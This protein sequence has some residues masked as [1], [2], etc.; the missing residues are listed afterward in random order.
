MLSGS[1][2]VEEPACE[3][4]IDP[5]ECEMAEEPGREMGVW[6]D[7]R[8]LVMLL[9]KRRIHDRG[10][11]FGV[12][13]RVPLPSSRSTT[14]SNARSLPMLKLVLGVSVLFCPTLALPERVF[15]FSPSL[16]DRGFCGVEKA[17][18]EL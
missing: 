7:S 5:L 12:T 9:D 13:A 16:T 15:P 3:K 18:G 10:R 8:E 2:G 1:I 14:R 11:V 4:A 17:K 6:L